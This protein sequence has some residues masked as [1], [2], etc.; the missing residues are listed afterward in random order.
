VEMPPAQNPP[1]E[2]DGDSDGSDC[3]V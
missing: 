1:R 2:A 3:Y